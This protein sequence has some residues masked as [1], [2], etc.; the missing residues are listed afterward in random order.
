MCGDG[1]NLAVR[2][3]KFHGG[4]ARGRAGNRVFAVMFALRNKSCIFVTFAHDQNSTNPQVRRFCF[5]AWPTQCSSGI[6]NMQF[7]TGDP[8][9]TKMPNLFVTAT[10]EGDA[11]V[12][13]RLWQAVIVSTI[14][15]WISGP[16]R[17]KRIAEEYLFQDRSDFPQV[18]QSAGLDVDR[19]RQQLTRLRTHSNPL[20]KI[21]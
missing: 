19:L 8:G 21:A 3:E 18:C 7:T 17:Y 1:E 11:Q 5:A 6:R 15:E 12:E 13:K 16:L 4:P 14:Q 20:G 2:R 10:T 9:G